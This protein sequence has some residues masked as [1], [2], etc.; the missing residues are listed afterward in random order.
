M[1]YYTEA[2]IDQAYDWLCRR[3]KDYHFN[4]D[5]W[6]LRFHWKSE[7]QKLIQELKDGT[8]RFDCV[9]KIYTPNR[10]TFLWPSR[11][12]LV[13]KAVAIYLE[14]ELRPILS[15]QIFHLAGTKENKK[16]SKAAVREVFDALPEY[17]FVFRTDVKSYYAS[18]DHDLLLQQIKKYVKDPFLC[19]LINDFLR[20]TVCDGGYYHSVQKGISLGCPLS[21]LLGALFLKPLDDAMEK[22]GLF[23]IRF[24]DDWVVL[25]PTR[26]KLRRAIAT[27]NQTL[28]DLKLRKHP[29]KTSIGRTDAGF[30]FL[31]YHFQ[32]VA[33]N[34]T[35]DVATRRIVLNIQETQVVCGHAEVVPIAQAHHT[36][37]PAQEALQ[38]NKAACGVRT[39]MPAAADR[40]V[41]LQPARKT[42]NNFFEKLS[43][44]YEQG[45]DVDRIGDYVGRW[46]KW[47]LSGLNNKLTSVLGRTGRTDVTT[48]QVE[49]GGLSPNS[50]LHNMFFCPR[51]TYYSHD[52]R[53]VSSYIMF[54]FNRLMRPDPI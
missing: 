38:G 14:K 53:V 26:W 18:I 43:R 37:G 25:S 16:G 4:N 46:W 11:D 19:R 30:D 49:K 35:A 1:S 45:A 39:D 13:L 23:Y 8:F 22:T 7:R 9:E 33:A 12:A 41:K 34:G 47:L 40:I 54:Y 5:V 24:M 42:V 28:C 50:I 20:H 29:D 51:K 52:M 27:V 3:R 21:P 44:L 17:N 31:G 2:I 48:E 15:D 6:H 32:T 10:T 36:A